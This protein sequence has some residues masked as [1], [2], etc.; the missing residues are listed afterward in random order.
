V[1]VDKQSDKPQQQ[2]VDT[3]HLSVNPQAGRSTSPLGRSVSW[4]E[5]RDE[6]LK[7][8][9]IAEAEKKEKEKERIAAIYKSKSGLSWKEQKE[10]DDKRKKEEADRKKKEALEQ[11]IKQREGSDNNHNYEEKIPTITTLHHVTPVAHTEAPAAEVKYREV[12]HH[13]VNPK[14]DI[15]IRGLH[16]DDE[17]EGARALQTDRDE[18]VRKEEEQ[19]SRMLGIKTDDME[20]KRKEEAEKKQKDDEAIEKKRKDEAEKKRK[21][22]EDEKKRKDEEAIEKKRKDDEAEKKRKDE[23]T[24]KK[25][26]A[27]EAEKKRKDDEAEKK[28]KRR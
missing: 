28:K 6:D 13:H 5:K 15:E 24:E 1:T 9:E 18:K 19:L 23:E 22:D 2:H 14:D 16:D 10:L 17:N 27:D 20:K 12:L 3:Q 8:R 11:V 26:K 25:R 4:K 21:A 7:K